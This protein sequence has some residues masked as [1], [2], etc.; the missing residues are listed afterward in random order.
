MQPDFKREVPEIKTERL[1]LRALRYSDAAAIFAYAQDPEVAQHTLWDPHKTLRDSHAFLDFVTDQ[2]RA[3]R[4]FVWGITVKPLDRVVG[5]VGLANVAAHHLRAE[6]GFALARDCWNKGITTEA[7]K[8][9]VEFGFS[10]FHLN[11][12]EAFCKTANLPSARVLEKS[13]LR[14]E[15]VLREHQFIK[16][17]FEDLK[18]Y[19]VLKSDLIPSNSGS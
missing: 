6:L 17:Q 15:G 9:V 18:L 14:L 7:A 1:V 10:K 19:A 12:I 2:F 5:T 8:A 11:R 13:G 16:G 3:G 4:M